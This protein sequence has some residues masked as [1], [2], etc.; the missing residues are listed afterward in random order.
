MA[1]S[2][3]LY[4]LKRILT[5]R[6]A[7]L[8]LLGVAITAAVGIQLCSRNVGL[9]IHHALITLEIFA[10]SLFIAWLLLTLIELIESRDR[11]FDILFLTIPIL[12]IGGMFLQ[13]L[14]KYHNAAFW[15]TLVIWTLL[16]TFVAVEEVQMVGKSDIFLVAIGATWSISGA[17][18]S[19]GTTSLLPYSRSAIGGLRSVHLF[20][21]LRYLLGSI[22][23]VALIAIAG[24]RALRERPP[25]IND[26]E[27][28]QVGEL[29]ED[30]V[31]AWLVRPFTTL[32][33]VLLLLVSVALDY[34]L[35]AARITVFYFAA[36]GRHIAEI[37][38][39]LV[40]SR[41]AWIKIGECVVIFLSIVLATVFLRN[42]CPF[43]LAYLRSSAW[44]A[45]TLNL[46]LIAGFVALILLCVGLALLIFS[47]YD[48]VFIE[49]LVAS[50]AT[51][52]SIVFAAGLL[53][54]A[55]AWLDVLVIHGFRVPGPFSILVIVLILSG[56]A[57]VIAQSTG[58]VT[59]NT[60]A[61]PNAKRAL[62]GRRQ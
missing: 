15:L 26:I 5:S 31:L 20:L 32:I 1:D 21:D 30:N 36:I 50:F 28:L 22:F 8:Y 23:L 52:V 57:K 55:L 9:S 4:D 44:G 38:V 16:G 6:G 56:I 37:V 41:E 42:F 18:I 49:P 24:A 25:A 58:G 47:E 39:S 59:S 34:L 61:G 54:Y 19:A 60:D 62:R 12:S 17:I 45:Q 46:A 2:S 11:V 51:V 29:A 43:L 13:I 7:L 3:T 27:A 40:K 48:D 35:K 10:Y 53:I 33:N 14:A